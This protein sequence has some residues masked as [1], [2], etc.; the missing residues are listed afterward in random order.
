V[1]RLATRAA[2]HII[3]LGAVAMFA[4]LLLAGCLWM[5]VGHAIGVELGRPFATQSAPPAV[6]A[7]ARRRSG[8]RTVDTAG[9]EAGSYSRFSSDQQG[10]SSIDQQRRKCREAAAANG[11][12]MRG[13]CEFADHAVSGTRP[14]RK[15]LQAMI[16]AAKGG[17]FQVLYFESL[18]RLAREFVISAPMLKELVYVHKIRII[19][20]SEGLDSERAGWEL[21]AMF[22]SWMHGEFLK[23]L[24]EA[25]LRGQEEAV[26]NDY[27]V[28][29][30]CFGYRSEPIPGSEAG[31]RGRNAKPRMRIFLNEEH[32]RWVVQ[33]FE[34][35]VNERRS[36]PWIARELTRLKAPKD[37]RATTPQW[38]ACY[39]TA[40]LRNQK[41]IGLWPWGLKTNVLNPVTGKISQEDCSPEEVLQ[42]LRER[43]S[44]RIVSDDLFFKAQGLLD[45]NERV[46][47]E[48][49]KSKGQLRGSTVDSQNPRHLL[50]GLIKCAACG[51][52]FRV[53][54]AQGKYL[55]CDGYSSGI[56]AVKTQL[57]RD[58]AESMILKR[59][60]SVILHDPVW[61]AS[62][63][64]S[65]DSEW[66]ARQRAQPDETKDIERQLAQVELKIGRLIDSVEDGRADDDTQLRLQLRRRERDELKRRLVPLHTAE[67]KAAAAPTPE[68]IDARLAE[69]DKL[70]TSGE[71]AGAVALREMIGCIKVQQIAT[72][73]RRAHLRG[74]FVIGL[75]PMIPSPADPPPELAARA[76][77][78]IDFVELPPWAAIA[79][80][81]KGLI[82]AGFLYADIAVQLGCIP[83]WPAKALAYW[84]EERGLPAPDGRSTRGRLS[85]T[86]EELALR[87]RAME[88][89]D[90]DLSM[91]DI[92]A[93][94]GC[95]LQTLKA[96]VA[97]WHTAQSLPIPDG[98]NRRADRGDR[99]ATPTEQ[100]A[101]PAL[102]ATPESEVQDVGNRSA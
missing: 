9:A 12:T 36:K 98:R 77:I 27:S 49:R 67:A 76:A 32:A 40:L 18:S 33:I 43:P 85:D 31:R 39:V 19:S 68:W 80:R 10:D 66:Q 44:L 74:T 62:V 17:S 83:S 5:Q 55:K 102:T 81:V 57:R 51:S 26:L 42:Y 91:Q 47:A 58:R 4:S 15:G 56:C 93:A 88:L 86:P 1:H 50:Q 64:A 13:D 24:R 101:D 75:L 63:C 35:F 71:P 16:A 73:G 87:Q 69:L 45:H 46:C 79:D 97:D 34:W 95:C 38:R 89:W 48:S 3:S 22:R 7:R 14:D 65:A 99:R 25:V 70:L 28:G 6:I 82:D 37:H 94:L 8:A 11:H 54:G 96:R 21:M 41:Y 60:G 78:T 100:P 92:A 53:A 20:T 2:A 90:T 23:Q 30:W 84:Y 52:T 59:V 61:R 29:D 72:P